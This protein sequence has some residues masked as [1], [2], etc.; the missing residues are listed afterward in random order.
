MKD[1]RDVIT[2][3]T[4]KLFFPLVLLGSLSIVFEKELATFPYIRILRICII[5]LA[6]IVVIGGIIELIKRKQ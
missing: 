6:I 4:N 3:V 5:V 1:V 2:K